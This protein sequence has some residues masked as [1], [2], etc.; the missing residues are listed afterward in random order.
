M[1]VDMLASSDALWKSGPDFSILGNFHSKQGRSYRRDAWSGYSRRPFSGLLRSWVIGRFVPVHLFIPRPAIVGHK[2]VKCFSFV[3]EPWLLQLPLV[4]NQ[5]LESDGGDG[6]DTQLSTADAGESGI[7]YRVEVATT[8]KKSEIPVASFE[9]GFPVEEPWLAESTIDYSFSNVNMTLDV[10]AC[11]EHTRSAENRQTTVPVASV[12]S[13]YPV[14]EPWLAESM[15][16]YSI[17]NLK[18]ASDVSTCEEHSRSAD[19]TGK[20]IECRVEGTTTYKNTG[21]PVVSFESGYPVEEPCLAEPMIDYSISNVKMTTGVSTCDEHFRSEKAY[22]GKGKEHFQEYEKQSP[23]ENTVITGDNSVNTVILI[24]SSV[25]TMQRIAVLENGRLVELLLEP[26]KNNVQCDSV[27]LG[28]ITCLTPQMGGAFVNIGNHQ[29]A[30]MNINIHKE[31]FIFPPF[32]DDRGRETIAYEPVKFGENSDLETEATLDEVI[33]DDD[34]DD[35][36]AE[37]LQD[38]CDQ[39]ENHDTDKNV[40]FRGNGTESDGHGIQRHHLKKNHNHDISKRMWAQVQKGTKIIVQVTKEGLGRKGPSVT[41]YPRLRSRF[42]VL[43]A[44]SNAIGISKKICGPERTRLRGIAETL[45]PPGFGI[46]L[47]TVAVGH[48]S[49][50]LKKDLEGL[51]STWKSI[52]EHAKSSALAADE[53]LDGAVPVMLHQA[54]SQTLSIVQDYFNGKVKSMVVDSRKIYHEVKNYLQEIAP[55]LCHRVELYIN[56]APLF[57]KYEIEGEIDNILI[58][59]VP[60]S[61]GGYLVIEQTEALFSIDVNGG[62]CMIGNGT[63][64]E[65]AIL[66][67]NLAAAR[68]IAREL[69][70]RDIGGLIVVDFIDMVDYSNKRLVYEEM[71]KAVER[72]RST[73]NVSELSTHGLME[74]TRKRVRPSVPFMISEP[75]TCCYG[76]GR[77]VALQTAFS[78]IERGI[79]RF[80]SRMNE[81]ANPEDPVS[82]PRFILMV[83]QYMYNYLTQGRKTKLDILS[84]SL[85]VW[86]VPK[87]CVINFTILDFLSS[88]IL[89]ISGGC[90]CSECMI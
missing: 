63:S 13:R 20:E 71:K 5:F 62:Q 19:T 31:P 60:L 53:G 74:I 49:D 86:V 75:C 7:E 48:S 15:I 16:D 1:I 14:E 55:N 41:P 39:H 68:Q 59:R 34:I 42:W 56:E 30:F 45:Q 46:T 24:N 52:R 69:R 35:D 70:L 78:K 54:M 8:D 89:W 90:Y 3:E 79:S 26:V 85:K 28:V 57:D 51:V 72:D 11:E 9:S 21:S 84:S 40:D 25:C 88:V 36:P 23:L 64:Q 73:V 44:S 2:S 58:N 27:Y 17:S 10:S 47:R 29:S 83:D 38:N 65:Q 6:I 50:D 4:S 12:E 22:H 81:K 18:M 76:T 66:E 67:V 80:L 77:V 43:R 32:S 61:N 87:V 33:E 82:W 37:Y